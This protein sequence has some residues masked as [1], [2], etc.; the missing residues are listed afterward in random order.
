MEP[1]GQGEGGGES[2]PPEE[3]VVAAVRSSTKQLQESVKTLVG[4]GLEK[5]SA[6]RACLPSVHMSALSGEGGMFISNLLLFSVN[7]EP[8]PAAAGGADSGPAR[9]HSTGERKAAYGP[10]KLP[11]D[12][13]QRF[14]L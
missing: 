1:L 3:V 12:E 11:D 10:M 6:I 9:H 7:P 13:L 2:A 5:I 4:G 8:L 14:L